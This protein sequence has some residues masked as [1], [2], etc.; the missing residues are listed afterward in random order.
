MMRCSFVDSQTER[1]SELHSASRACP[2]TVRPLRVELLDVGFDEHRPE[3][4]A[5][6]SDRAAT[7]RTDVPG[8]LRLGV[9]ASLSKAVQSNAAGCG[10]RVA[11][12]S[13][14]H[15]AVGQQDGRGHDMRVGA[16]SRERFFAA[17][18][19]SAKLT[20]AVLLSPT[21]SVMVTM[22]RAVRVACDR[23]VDARE[24]GAGQRQ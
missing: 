17:A 7:T 2:D 15:T 13:G 10:W 1:P 20:L 22:S 9:A 14:E 6:E 3:Q 18:L 12:V 19:A 8:E 5:A 21:I 23:E 4:L 16:K 11:I 24:D